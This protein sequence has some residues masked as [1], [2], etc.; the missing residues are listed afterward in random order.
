MRADDLAPGDVDQGPAINTIRT[1]QIK[2]EDRLAQRR[3]AAAMLLDQNDQRQQ[4]R[5]VPRRLEELRERVERAVLCLARRR[6]DLRHRQTEEAIAFAV[7]AGTG[8]EEAEAV[9]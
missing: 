7:L 5:L 9:F 6:A 2:P 8:A 1:I 4:P 3:I